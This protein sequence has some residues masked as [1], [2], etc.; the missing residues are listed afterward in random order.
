MLASA[1]KFKVKKF[2]FSSSACMYPVTKQLDV[3]VPAL[4]ETDAWPADLRNNAYGLEKCV[5]EEACRWTELE[6]PG[7]EVRIGRF[8]KYLRGFMSL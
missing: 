8:R 1:T 4:K 6:N 5:M 3:D 7:F 2:F